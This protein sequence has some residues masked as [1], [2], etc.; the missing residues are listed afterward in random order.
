MKIE[1]Y[2]E[3]ID[4]MIKSMSMKGTVPPKKLREL[5]IQLQTIG[6]K[7]VIVSPDIVVEKFITWRALTQGGPDPEGVFKAFADLLIEMRKEIYV[8]T[9]RTSGDVLDILS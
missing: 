6:L 4:F 9:E 8:N 2:N 7:M 3:F 5:G 1:L